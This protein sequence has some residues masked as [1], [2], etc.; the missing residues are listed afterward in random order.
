MHIQILQERG[1]SNSATDDDLPKKHNELPCIFQSVLLAHSPGL[2]LS[3]PTA[4]LSWSMIL[5]RYL[6]TALRGMADQCLR[7]WTVPQTVAFG[8]IW[9]KVF[10]MRELGEVPEEARE[11]AMSRFRLIQPHLEKNQPLQAVAADGEVP[12]R[13]AQRWVSQY[14]IFGLIALARKTRTDRGSRKVISPK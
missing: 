2:A 14:R 7:F 12:F 9:R 8:I 6:A 1:L 3:M 11:L 10:D 13:T 5:C 4:F